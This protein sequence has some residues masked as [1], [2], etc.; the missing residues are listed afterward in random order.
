LAVTVALGFRRLLLAQVLA[1]LAAGVVVT[2]TWLLPL[3]LEAVTVAV[4]PMALMLRLI[5]G[6]AAVVEAVMGLTLGL[7]GMVAPV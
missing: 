7:A 2:A 1:V 6:A 5:L 4:V 3:Q